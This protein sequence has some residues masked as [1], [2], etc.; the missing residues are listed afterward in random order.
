M[1]SGLTSSNTVTIKG[2][3]ATAQVAQFNGTSGDLATVGAG[4]IARV[5][6]V[7][8]YTPFRSGATGTSLATVKANGNSILTLTENYVTGGTPGQVI[9]LDFEYAQTIQISAGQKFTWT[10]TGS[11]DSLAGCGIVYVEEDIPT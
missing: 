2:K 1:A 6:K 10:Y 9:V 7:F 8:I 11:A 3:N 5:L 4:K